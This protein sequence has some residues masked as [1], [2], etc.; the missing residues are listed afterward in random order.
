MSQ[1]SPGPNTK[2]LSIRMDRTL[3]AE[4]ERHAKLEDRSVTN[5]I[6]HRMR[7]VLRPMDGPALVRE[8]VRESMRKL[9]EEP[10][11]T[12]TDPPLAGHIGNGFLPGTL[13]LPEMQMVYGEPGSAHEQR[14]AIILNAHTFEPGTEPDTQFCLRCGLR[15]A[16]SVHGVAAETRS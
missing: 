12:P 14:A 1:P 3:F 7:A 11:G 10:A 13:P 2:L 6:V 15:E 5:F 4:I 16:D 8:Q 9:R